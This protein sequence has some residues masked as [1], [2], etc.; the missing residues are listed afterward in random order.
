MK[1]NARIAK[2]STLFPNLFS[3]VL[4]AAMLIAVV[5]GCS[6]IPDPMG[7]IEEDNQAPPEELTE[8]QPSVK[9]TS[10]WSTDTGAGSDEQYLKLVPA[11]YGDQVFV[12]DNEG[13]VRSLSRSNG[14]TSWSRD[15]E[16]PVSGG[17]GVG[18]GVVLVGT[19]DAEV[20]ALDAD[21]GEELWRK[22]LS[23]EILSV[24][25]VAGGISVV[26]TI[27]G[28]VYGLDTTSG[29]QIWVYDRTVPVLT[30]RGDSSP[31]IDGSNVVV[32]FANGKLI[33]LDLYTGDPRWDTLVSPPRGRTELERIAD[34][35]ADPVIDGGVIYVSTYQGEVAALA[36]VNGMVGWRR[37]IS[38]YSG[39]A[40]D[41]RQLYVT[42]AKGRVW[43]LDRFNGAS[44]WKQEKLL[45]R[46]LTAPAVLGDYILVGDLEGYVH[47]LSYDD[48]SQ[49][50]RVEVSGAPITAPPRVV[51]DVAYV[52]SDDG[53]LTALTAGD[54]VEY[55]Y[56]EEETEESSW[57]SDDSEEEEKDSGYFWESD[58]EEEKSEEESEEKE[59]SGYFWESDDEETSDAEEVSDDEE[60]PEDDYEDDYEGEDYDSGQGRI[61]PPLRF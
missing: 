60:E 15:T 30:L 58:D 57:D 41:S 12:A 27:D 16:A 51:D 49:K 17:P 3:G 46:R 28:R 38:S 19:R 22:R 44:L 2:R 21:N 34:I 37:D 45:N 5:G 61:L 47:F 36:L 35:D 8:Y 26:R 10:R 55:E 59:D 20:I 50:G 18:D 23:N 13:E 9:P 52:F 56:E 32:G 31:V 54:M 4:P 33:N 1:H 53:K 14:K 29:D 48:G 24:P 43:A 6:S 11:F 25:Q 39:M 42:D 7:W 40:L